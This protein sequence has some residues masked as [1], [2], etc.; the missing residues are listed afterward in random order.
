MEL[1]KGYVIFLTKDW[2]PIVQNLIESVLLFSKYKIEI[3]CINFNY[4]FTNE[5]IKSNLINLDN[6]DFFNITKCKIISTINSEF[7]IGLILD[8]DM[9]VTKDIDKIFSD[10]EHRIKKCDFP[11][12]AKHPHNPFDRYRHITS[13]VSNSQ[14]KMKWVYSN[15]L[16]AKHHKWFF[17]ETL[18]YMNSIPENQHDFFYP[19]PEESILN[20]LLSKYE[21]D[22]DLGYNYFPNGLKCVIDNY[23]NHDENGEK[24][25]QETYLNYDCP[26]KFYAFH[27]HDL[28]NIEY[29]KQVIKQI[30]NKIT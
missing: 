16:F 10:N 25:I 20:A 13:F 14:N 9:I 21:V 7:D 29:G 2:L 17:T 15:Y 5:R 27:G 26:I 1:N 19:V 11:L 4:D 24:H 30:Q 28:K 3:N 12:F 8:G 22:Y 23:V 6:P 18:N